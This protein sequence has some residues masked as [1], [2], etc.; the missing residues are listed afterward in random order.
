M[1]LWASLPLWLLLLTGLLL[2]PVLT[3]LMLWLYRLLPGQPVARLLLWLSV[4]EL[5]LR[6]LLLLPGRLM[7]PLL[8]LRKMLLLLP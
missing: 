8:Q 1:G 3:A 4:L 6:L 5:V 2:F 7:R